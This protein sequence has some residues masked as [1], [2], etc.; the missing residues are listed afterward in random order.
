MKS[1]CLV[2]VLCIQVDPTDE[3]ETDDIDLMLTFV[4]K[5]NQMKCVVVVA[6]CRIHFDYFF[7]DQ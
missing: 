5:A 4:I 2:S 3:K 6:I 7:C 1:V